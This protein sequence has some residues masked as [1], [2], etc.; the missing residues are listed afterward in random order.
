MSDLLCA[1]Q[2]L[3]SQNQASLGLT[4]C[5]K[6]AA[7]LINLRPSQILLTKN[8]RLQTHNRDFTYSKSSDT[9]TDFT[10]LIIKLCLGQVELLSLDREAL[11][12]SCV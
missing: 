9:S 4:L 11:E 6:L 1:L 3:V 8:F 10:K 7:P 12:T 2:N 5:D